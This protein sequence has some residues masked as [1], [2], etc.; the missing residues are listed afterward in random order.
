[1]DDRFDPAAPLVPAGVDNVARSDD[2]DLSAVPQFLA[3]AIHEGSGQSEAGPDPEPHGHRQR[4]V[5]VAQSAVLVADPSALPMATISPRRLLHAVAV[6]ALA[7]GVISFGRQVATASAAS[8][9]ADALRSATA[10]MQADV[11]AMQRELVLVQEARYVDQQARAYRLGTPAEIPFALQ[12]GASPLPADAPGSA[13]VRVGAPAT[14]S[15]PLDSWLRVL[16]GP[17]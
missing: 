12:S 9:Q 6:I 10:R 17:G 1:M 16:F 7:W 14:A 11:T 15:G 2:T 8:A 13:S 4:R 5:G 3:G